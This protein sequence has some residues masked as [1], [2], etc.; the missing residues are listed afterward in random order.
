MRIISILALTLFGLSAHAQVEELFKEVV[1]VCTIVTIT[2]TGD[3]LDASFRWS[4]QDPS[5]GGH[6]GGERVFKQGNDEIVAIGD[7]VW[8]GVA[9]WRSGKKLGE[10]VTVITE[11]NAD[12]RVL[13]LMN[14]NNDEERVQ[15]DC[16]KPIGEN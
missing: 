10:A 4:S 9:W 1:F 6:G 16:S 14:P 3:D 2:N 15:M 13:L 12:S 7:D 11:R 8:M 5:G